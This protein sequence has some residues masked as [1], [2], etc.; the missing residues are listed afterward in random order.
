MEM[1]E[2]RRMDDNEDDL[3]LLFGIPP[4]MMPTESE[5]VDELGRALPDATHPQ[6][7]LRRERRNSRAKRHRA[8]D[9]N[10]ASGY[11]TD[12]TL[13]LSDLQDFQ[14]ALNSLKDKIQ[15]ILFSDVKAK[16]F[17]DPKNGI[18]IWFKDWREKYSGE[19]N[20]AFGGMGLV[21][22]WGFWA[23]TELLGW[24]PLENEPRLDEF[25][26]YSRLHE[27]S[28]PEGDYEEEEGLRPEDD[29]PAQ[30]VGT[31]LVPRLNALILGGAFDPYSRRQIPTLIDLVEQI[32]ATL[33]SDHARFGVSGIFYYYYDDVLTVLM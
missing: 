27:Y 23:R 7:P 5:G 19:Y 29:L 13:S 11:S 28:H 17:K 21:Q 9:Q 20:N 12:S 18:L 2:K 14:I 4:D 3:V 15:S 24:L 6:S 26:W 1:I 31:M 33:G 8:D 32:E 25:K 30:M 16:A 22:A 10:N